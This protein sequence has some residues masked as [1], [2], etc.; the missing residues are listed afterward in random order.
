MPRDEIGVVDYF[1]ETQGE[2]GDRLDGKTASAKM[3]MARREDVKQA[4]L[5]RFNCLLYSY[6]IFNVLSIPCT[7]TSL[8]TVSWFHYA[9]ATNSL[10]TVGT[11][12]V[13]SEDW[14]VA[15]NGLAI[16]VEYCD[17]SDGKCDVSMDDFRY[18]KPAPDPAGFQWPAGAW[19]DAAA[20]AD[21][22]TT[23]LLA[24]V[25]V[26]FVCNIA[27]TVT[28]SLAFCN[29]DTRFRMIMGTLASVVALVSLVLGILG[30]VK[31]LTDFISL[32]ETD[33][34]VDAEYTPPLTQSY[35]LYSIGAT[36]GCQLV[37]AIV[38]F[39]LIKPKDECPDHILAEIEKHRTV[40]GKRTDKYCKDRDATTHITEKT[41]VDS[42]EG[43]AHKGIGWTMDVF[44]EQCNVM[45]T[46]D[47]CVN[48]P[49]EIINPPLRLEPIRPINKDTAVATELIE[50][51]VSPTGF[52][53]ELCLDVSH[54]VPQNLPGS[55]ACTQAIHG[56]S[57]S[58]NLEKLRVATKQRT[59]KVT[60]CPPQETKRSRAKER[61]EVVISMNSYVAP[62]ERVA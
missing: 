23:Y 29:R 15:I 43:G 41:P 18:F 62:T 38:M 42:F 30:F 26:Y 27:V 40:R 31:S 17:E 5:N 52:S 58:K 60:R 13:L 50:A 3:G 47:H 51:P 55:V 48:H 45:H 33:N 8:L 2:K 28:M 37:C 20:K 4:K 22:G 61:A 39:M 21:T 32:L 49:L 9:G 46:E 25:G 10:S 53:A 54:L 36:V 16:H 57:K 59:R 24:G 44:T 7:A 35:S 11:K 12:I 56:F 14:A 1:Q 34:Y 19:A 6:I